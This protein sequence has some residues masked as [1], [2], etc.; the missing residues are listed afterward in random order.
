MPQFLR[1]Y[2]QFLR[3][4]IAWWLVPFVAIL[5]MLFG[6]AWLGESQPSFIYPLF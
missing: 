2:L 3:R 6:L 4:D 5:L 1:D